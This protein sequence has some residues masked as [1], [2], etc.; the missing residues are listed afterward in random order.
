MNALA[1]H[2][3]NQAQQHGV[4]IHSGVHILSVRPQG[5]GWLAQADNQMQY[6]AQHLLITLPPP[7]ALALFHGNEATLMQRDHEALAAISYDPCL[8]GLFWVEGKVYLPQPGAYQ[9]PGETVSWVADNQRKGISPEATLLT[10]HAGADFSRQ[11]YDQSDD[12]LFLPLVEGILPF[13]DKAAVIRQAQIKRWRYSQATT[14]Y[15]ERYLHAADVPPLYFGG[16]AFGAPRLE[17]AAL[18]GLMI[19]QAIQ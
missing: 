1:K 17:G 18:S 12:D 4:T 3:A 14:I 9:R 10:V 13:L 7:Q 6:S 5:K 2:L 11:H 15:P 19:A 8:C 16:D